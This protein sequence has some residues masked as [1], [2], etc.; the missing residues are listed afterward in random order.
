MELLM[1]SLHL[2]TCL[3]Q[4]IILCVFD[5]KHFCKFLVFLNTYSIGSK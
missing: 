5:R 3:S 1:A 4:P 2:S